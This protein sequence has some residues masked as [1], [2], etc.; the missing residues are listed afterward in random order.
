MLA[1]GKHAKVYTVTSLSDLPLKGQ[2]SKN[3]QISDY[4]T[5]VT[6]QRSQFL[7]VAKVVFYG[8]FYF[9]VGGSCKGGSCCQLIETQLPVN[10]LGR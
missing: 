8:T 2:R 4:Q 9:D 10:T 7:H 5:F 3:G 1:L 6:L